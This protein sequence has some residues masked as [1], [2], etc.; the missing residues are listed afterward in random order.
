MG[1]GVAG[2]VVNLLEVTMRTGNH[3]FRRAVT[4][5]RRSSVGLDTAGHALLIRSSGFPMRILF[6]QSSSVPRSMTAKITSLNVMKRGRFTRGKRRTRVVGHLNFDGYH[7]SLTVPGSVSC[8]N[9][10]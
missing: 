10:R 3:L 7:L 1:H 5:L 6:L 2:G 4:L 9:I 8:P